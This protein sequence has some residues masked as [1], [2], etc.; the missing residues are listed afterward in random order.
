MTSKRFRGH[1]NFYNMENINQEQIST[2]LNGRDGQEGIITVECNGKD[3]VAY[4]IYRLP[5][6][7]KRMKKEHYYPFLWITRKSFNGMCNGDTKERDKL[8]KEKDVLAKNL[9]I[10]N[11]DNKTNARMTEG[12]NILVQSKNPMSFNAFQGLFKKCGIDIYDR[13]AGVLRVTPVEQFLIQTGKRMFKG[14]ED[15]DNLVRLSFDLETD[16]L[17]PT[18]DCINQIGIR[19][20]KG[21]EYVIRIDGD[22]ED[23]KHKNEVKG[24]KQFWEFVQKIKPDVICG[25][26]S[27]N[28]DHPFMF[29]R[30]NANYTTIEEITQ[31][32][33]EAPYKKKN[34]TILKLGGEMEYFRQTVVWGYN[35]TDSLHAVRR[36]QA[37]DSNMK[38]AD[39][40]YVTKY[41]KLNKRNRV[42]VPG[43]KINKL[44][45]DFKS[46]YALNN[47]NGNWYQI[48]EEKPLQ[49]G[50]ELVKGD[51]IVE[52]YLLDDL[53]E[54]DKVELTYN[55]S[56]FLL[57]KMLPTTF[58]RVCTMGTAGTWKL[59]LMAWSYEQGIGIPA[60]G[61]K[62]DF[63]GGLSR[64]LSVGY[65]ARVVKLDYNSLYPAIILSFGIQSEVDITG[66]M[67]TLLE[68]MLSK[69]EEYKE[70][71][72]AAGKKADKIEEELKQVG[73]SEEQILR[74][75]NEKQKFKAEQNSFDKKQLP[76][77]IFCNSFFGGFGAPYLFPWGDTLCAEATTCIGRQSL[78]LMI[79][80]FS[81]RGYK[82]IVGDSF[83]YDT[84]MY[85][86]YNKTGIVDI[87]PISSIFDET[88]M[89]V[90]ALGREYDC[91]EKDFKV[92]CRSGW[93][94]P[95]YVYRHK[96]DKKIRRIKT[97]TCLV[98]VTEDHSLFDE[99]GNK[100]HPKDAHI[101]TKIELYK[102]NVEFSNEN[103]ELPN[104]WKLNEDS[105]WLMG[106]FLADGS[107]VYE[108]R[109]N[110]YFSKR[111]QKIH[112]N[113]G[114]RGS[115]TMNKLDNSKLE[116]ANE[117][118]FNEFGVKAT[119]KDY[120]QSSGVYKIKTENAALSKFFSEHF[121]TK[122]RYN[123]KNTR[124]KKVPYFILNSSNEIKKAFL[125]G[126][127]Y[128]DGHKEVNDISEAT[129]FCQKSKVCIAGLLLLCNS[130][131]IKY[132]IANELKRQ[133]SINIKLNEEKQTSRTKTN[134]FYKSL[135][136]DEISYNEVHENYDIE[137]YVYDI[138]LDGSVVECIGN[139]I[140]TQ[141]DGFN[142]QM[143][144]EEELEKR[145]YIGKGLNRNT[146][147]GKVYK[148]VEADVAEFNDLF[149]RDKMG[150]GLDEYASATINFARKNYA[151][152]LLNH[153]TGALE[154]KLVGNTVK[155][156]KMPVY[157]EKF[158]DE[159]ISLLLK[160][161]GQ[162]FIEK[163]YE[164]IEKI[165]S[166]K[167]P[168]R[169]IA[170]KGKIKKPIAEYIE[171]CKSRTKAGTYKSRQAWYELAIQNDL[172]VNMGDTIYYVN[173]GKAKSHADIKMIRDKDEN[174]QSL[175]T[176]EIQ[177]NCI[178]IDNKTI[179][180]END[181]FGEYNRAKYIEQFNKRINPLIVCFSKD[182]RD[183]IIV[184]TPEE[185]SYFT[186]SQCV[187]TA[188]E[189]MKE[190]QQDTY[191]Q[192]MTL[193]DKEINFW[194]RYGKEPQ[195]CKE[196]GMD[197]D[198]IIDGYEQ[199]LK[200]LEIDE[201]KS[202]LIKY[203]TIIS[204]LTNEDVDNIIINSKMP[205]QITD[206]LNIN[207][208]NKTFESK[209]YGCRIGSIF[210]IIERNEFE[211]DDNLVIE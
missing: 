96:T 151:D 153:K 160:G 101:G 37:I 34:A 71:K 51:Y 164:Q 142:Y 158:M 176:G 171:D 115:F 141:T 80:W 77:K 61:K 178:M 187:L 90:D 185:R 149:M 126:F 144:S 159:G 140:I 24:I 64:L 152:L 13:N 39:L 113:A 5:N 86:K 19:S 83:L 148:K 66:V 188:G 15:Y 107:S 11:A 65:V 117:I 74:L 70:A 48:T 177:F 195:F 105:A 99:N 202:E 123:K 211:T 119:I 91:S 132:T 103:M 100:L 17:D 94:E 35:I 155:S 21:F 209:K 67:N 106:F 28:F 165:Y 53:Y 43:D 92:L 173:T 200:N 156:K 33:H 22:N 25:H 192:L 88:K 125:D 179:E 44:W 174:G 169:E 29:E 50:F 23:E 56:N 134:E 31:Q 193:D 130:L 40:K 6:G 163:Y 116:R 111:D 154:V 196:I 20:N 36:A 143:P 118:L 63:V 79:Q 186:E 108:F 127:Y 198:E 133:H 109:H 49:D 16:G 93:L 52:R 124:E 57:G 7:E 75:T 135:K 175:V 4:I 98:D 18:K 210:D 128:G 12:Y 104:G 30:L 10:F 167:V 138:S 8:L 205:K 168:L 41:S 122:E 1:F 59:I 137:N 131:G 81:K 206:F 78:R 14:Y 166:C 136:N 114:K 181:T 139:Q 89:G 26:N 45:Y 110:K 189:P 76:F 38:K 184:K 54:T 180:S 170:S 201:I 121:Y 97:K 58:G 147:E 3:S 42:Y 191:E 62:Q 68:Y 102:K 172:N 46:N 9:N 85:V 32:M 208:E 203:K 146:V 82:P 69:R 112:Y 162:E 183:K 120:I 197:W 157:I 84:P 73:L 55:Q 150:L 204:N 47:E 95:K 87:M 27:E 2:F 129:Y 190:E 207:I 194:L 60:L 182:I 199:R 72:S 161:K 145:V